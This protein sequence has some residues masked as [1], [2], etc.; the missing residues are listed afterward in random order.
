LQ[1]HDGFT[2]ISTMETIFY[3]K[4]QI[5]KVFPEAS[6]INVEND[7][8]VT[9]NESTLNTT[10]SNMKIFCVDELNNSN[11]TGLI[12]NTTSIKCLSVTKNDSISFNF[13]IVLVVNSFKMVL[14]SQP[15]PFFVISLFICFNFQSQI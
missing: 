2:F 8:I 15:V 6:L 9:F 5:Q 13:N 10:F 1:F 3:K 14:N 11:F 12:I 7:L 4:K